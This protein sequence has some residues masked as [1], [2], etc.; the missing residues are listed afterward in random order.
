MYVQCDIK[1]QMR[2]ISFKEGFPKDHLQFLNQLPVKFPA[3]SVAPCNEVRSIGNR[4]FADT[5]ATARAIRIS[6][7][8]STIIATSL[9][10]VSTIIATSLTML[11]KTR[12]EIFTSDIR[13]L[14]PPGAEGVKTLKYQSPALIAQAQV[15][16]SYWGRVDAT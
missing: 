16:R 3:N 10:R 12:K 14:R 7:T 9:A 15:L 13:V 11:S 8:L 6:A 1:G 5:R 4:T 2:Y